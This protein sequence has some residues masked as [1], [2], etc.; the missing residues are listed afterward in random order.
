MEKSAKIIIRYI[1]KNTNGC[2]IMK[3]TSVDDNVV[4]NELSFTDGRNALISCCDFFVP[5][6]VNT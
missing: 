5:R 2:R 6:L 1:T 3:A 4:Q